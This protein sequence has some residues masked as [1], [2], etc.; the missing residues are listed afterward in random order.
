MGCAQRVGQDLGYWG[1][2]EGY[3]QL[4]L[5]CRTS[6]NKFNGFC[7][8][9]VCWWGRWRITGV[10][11]HGTKETGEGVS[12]TLRWLMLHVG[13]WIFWLGLLSQYEPK[14]KF[15]GSWCC[16]SIVLVSTR[17]LA[18]LQ[19]CDLHIPAIGPAQP[20]GRTVILISCP[21]SCS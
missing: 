13:K 20:Q 3:S 1:K 15:I 7:V 9:V 12:I 6:Q 8:G 19:R 5:G 11:V 10:S 4:L 17:I 16:R 2:K 21:S 14:H 18:Q